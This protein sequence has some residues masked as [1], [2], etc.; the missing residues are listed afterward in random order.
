M[1]YCYYY[2]YYSYCYY[3]YSLL[4]LLYRS[5]AAAD[6]RSLAFSRFVLL[7]TASSWGPKRHKKISIGRKSPPVRASKHATAAGPFFLGRS[8]V[9]VRDVCCRP[10]GGVG[11]ALRRDSGRRRDCADGFRPRVFCGIRRGSTV[12]VLK[13]RV[14]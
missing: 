9:R 2:S 6:S 5:F 1:Y 8:F 13:P 14:L 3:C 11:E 12:D 10:R 4:L 7:E